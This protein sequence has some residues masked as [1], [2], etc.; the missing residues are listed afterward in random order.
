MSDAK[1][2]SAGERWDCHFHVFDNSRY[3][4]APGCAYVPADAPLDTFRALCRSRGIGRAVLVHPSVYGADHTSF[5]DALTTDGDWLRG[6]AV[7]YPDQA[8]TSDAQIERWHTLGA[9]GTRI[10]RLFP[11][12]PDNVDRVVDRVAPLGWHVQL[13]VD[14]VAD[15]DIVRRIAAR[16]VPVVI[17]HF[18]HHPVEAL[19][20][21]A[22]FAD[23][24]SLMREGL[25]WVKLSGA[26]RVQRTAGPWA[27]VQPL[28]E[29]LAGA[30]DR[31]LVWG[32]DWPHPSSAVHPFPPPDEDEIGR[33]VAQWLQ[34]SELA[35]RVMRDNPARLYDPAVETG[36]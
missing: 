8:V 10:N 36:R 1:P 20:A 33:T 26:Y 32:S 13:L 9:R 14:L 7:V 22:A 2:W 18:G 23:L 16:G 29:A 24:L 19:L 11:G 15:I 12:A 28:V 31:Q 5:E 3:P 34:R 27:S 21:S 6:V 4:L 25:A 30:N 17:D 35:D